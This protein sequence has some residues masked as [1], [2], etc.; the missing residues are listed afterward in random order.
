[1]AHSQDPAD[2]TGISVLEGTDGTSAIRPRERKANV[3]LEMRLAGYQWDEVADVVGYPDA[4]A[5][6]VAF[7]TALE[8]QLQ[9]DPQMRSKMREYTGRR[10]E[11]L[12]RAVWSK[13][14]DPENPEQMVAHQRALSVIDRHAKLFGLDAPTEV[15]VHTPTADELQ[16]WVADVIIAK[17]DLAPEADIFG[18][19]APQ[20]AGTYTITAVGEEREPDAPPSE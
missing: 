1:M 8:K 11:R 17:K 10:L 13:A 6:Q 5:A 20:H 2:P 18:E 14:I 15:V 12:L 7:E 16:N 3:A 19:D 4:R 9:S